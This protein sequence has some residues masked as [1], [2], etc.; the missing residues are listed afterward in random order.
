VE[1]LIEGEKEDWYNVYV[2]VGVKQEAG[3]KPGAE[4]KVGK[5]VRKGWLQKKDVG[6]I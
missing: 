6:V 5:E 4:E 1:C 2:Y 3:S